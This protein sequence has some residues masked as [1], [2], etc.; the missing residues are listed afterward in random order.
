MKEA[1]I[2]ITGGT[3]LTLDER[4]RRIEGG[5][6]AICGDTIVGIGVSEEIEDQFTTHSL[7]DANDCMVMPGLVNGHTHAAMTC[8]RGVADDRELMSWLN[9][10]IFPLEA[11]HVSPELAHWGSL[12][13]CAE[14][15][16]SGTTTFCD[17]YIFEDET[18]RAAK[19][20]GM[21]CVLG[22]GL[23]DFPTANA[24]TPADGLKC[25]RALIE[26][27][28]GDPL[29]NIV[30][31]P[32]SLYTCSPPV[33]VGAKRI[34]DEYGLPYALHLLENQAERL[35][36]EQKFSKSPLEFLRELGYLTERFLAYHCVA[37]DTE[38]I[39]FLADNGC[40]VIHTPESNMK[41]GSG[42]APVP[43]MLKAGI[44]VGLGTDGPASNNN[45]DLFG[46]MNAAAKLHKVAGLDPTAM[47]AGSTIRMATR[48]GAK[49]LGL[50]S[51][52]G[53]LETGKKADVIVLDTR[54]PH[55]T[56][57]YQEYSQLVYAACGADVDTVI[58]NGKPVMRNRKLLTVDER[59][60]MAN[61]REIARR[62]HES[63]TGG[64]N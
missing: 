43:A 45:L 34:A 21:R 46:E 7:I 15:I 5:G 14:M 1:D 28:T 57:L 52:T 40:A 48:E 37:L 2:L 23:L 51:I 42:V 38:D 61:V 22:E 64:G 17:M 41:L 24:P 11:K 12:L 31:H 32:H 35:H 16:R 8:F 19:Q 26:R 39:R 13:A 58:I 10:F 20:A 54:K 30:V 63:L 36:L 9:D 56:P 27:W 4:D 55:L 47:D 3:I 49:A 29:V 60:V 62:I 33:L 53:S 18:A 59:E 6:L 50:G 44:R 25:T